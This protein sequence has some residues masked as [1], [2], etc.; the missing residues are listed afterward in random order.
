[1]CGQKNHM[2]SKQTEL[3]PKNIFQ[4]YKSCCGRTE[5]SSGAVV[6]LRVVD[7]AVNDRRRHRVVA[8]W[9]GCVVQRQVGVGGYD[10]FGGEDSLKHINA[11]G[12]KQ[13][14]KVRV[15]KQHVHHST[16]RFHKGVHDLTKSSGVLHGTQ[17]TGGAQRSKRSKGR[18]IGKKRQFR[19]QTNDDD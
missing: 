11:Q 4:Q 16:K 10:T 17:D 9:K 15:D 12:S 5:S 19:Q 18:Q 1:M 6:A 3:L 7:H 2:W 13:K 14:N 8:G